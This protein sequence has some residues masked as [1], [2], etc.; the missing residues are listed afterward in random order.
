MTLQQL[1]KTMGVGT[2]QSSQF[3]EQD[4]TGSRNDKPYGNKGGRFRND[5]GGY[6]D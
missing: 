2:S 1:Q 4:T 3:Q 5:G 6:N